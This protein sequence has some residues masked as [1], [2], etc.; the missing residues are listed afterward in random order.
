MNQRQ[1]NLIMS[2]KIALSRRTVDQDDIDYAKAC[3]TMALFNSGNDMPKCPICDRRDDNHLQDK[4]HK[5]V[6]E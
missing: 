2:A 4:A 5:A 3:L 1:I 6:T